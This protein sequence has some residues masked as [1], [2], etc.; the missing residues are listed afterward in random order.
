MLHMV[1]IP[2]WV[3]VLKRVFLMPFASR[4]DSSSARRRR[5][6]D[7]FPHEVTLVALLM[8]EAGESISGAV[9]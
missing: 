5:R 6:S 1:P 2:G 7:M 8:T 9:A 3:D 4:E